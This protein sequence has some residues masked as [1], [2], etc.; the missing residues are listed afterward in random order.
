SGL[1]QGY[2]C[3]QPIAVRSLDGVD[4]DWWVCA[5]DACASS[6]DNWQLACR[7]QSDCTLT[8]ADDHV[9]VVRLPADTRSEMLADPNS[10]PRIY[11]NNL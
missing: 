2:L 4:G 7:N 5:G 6:S 10:L 11:S 3:G 8:M 1:C 9:V